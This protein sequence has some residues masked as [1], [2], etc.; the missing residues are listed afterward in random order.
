MDSDGTSLDI[1]PGNAALA[2]LER[3][4]FDDPWTAEDYARLRGNPGAVAWILR[5]GARLALGFVCMQQ[6]A[7]E[8]EIYRIAVAPEQRR[9]GRARRLLGEVIMHAAREGLRQVFL[10]VRAGNAAARGLYTAMGFEQAALR[11]GYF[12][13][14]P[15][16]ALV[17]RCI[18]AGKKD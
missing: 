6:A 1:Q 3:R 13:Q 8:L 5:D 4:C 9:K 17:Y 16:D 15:E 7:G 10:E 14:P 12:K 2:A 11:K 18:P